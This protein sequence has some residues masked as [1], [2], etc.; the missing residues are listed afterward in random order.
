MLYE[1]MPKYRQLSCI[2]LFVSGKILKITLTSSFISIYRWCLHVIG[3]L[4]D[5][6]LII[7]HQRN[8]W[9]VFASPHEVF[10][11]SPARMFPSSDYHGMVPQSSWPE[12][13]HVTPSFQKEAEAA[14][15][16]KFWNILVQLRVYF[17]THNS[18]VWKRARLYK[19]PFI[20]RVY[21]IP[22]HIGI[23]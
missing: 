7:F 21:D 15:Q 3:G 16:V 10:A 9:K 19:L 20:T 6:F 5:A 12:R 22:K 18:I 23:N 13:P 14:M 2:I 11:S 1:L 8:I 17:V 4:D